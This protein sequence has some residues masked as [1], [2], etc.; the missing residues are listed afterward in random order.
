[1][2]MRP[3]LGTLFALTL[4]LG[5]CGD[6]AVER[7]GDGASTGTAT[8]SP[9]S[10]TGTPSA[11]P[12]DFTLVALVSESNVGGEVDPEATALD[13]EDAV[14]DFAAQFEDSRMVERLQAEVAGADVPVGQ[15]L[16]GAVVSIACDA[17]A[18][19]YVEWADGGL[20]VTGS[21]VKT[22][23]QCLVPVT[24]V[25]LVAVDAALV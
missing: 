17:P 18:E 9:S 13:S 14:A 21:Q 4:L 16:V 3:L 20:R 10:S 24:T 23:K 25:A 1:M 11:G 19:V 12:V 5:G 8:T 15:T 2:V 7:A 6:D 22:D